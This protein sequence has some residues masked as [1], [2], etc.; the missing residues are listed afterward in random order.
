VELRSLQYFVTVAEELHFGRAAERLNIA[1][2]AVSQQVARLE[3]EL[4]VRLLDRSPRRV[5]LTPSGLRV[6]D[7]ARATLAAAA[8]VRVV[9]GE[10][11]ARVRIG[12]ASGLT[13][14]VERGAAFLRGAQRRTAP[15]LVDLPTPQRLDALRDGELDVALVR[16]PVTEPGVR[17]V[18]AWSEPLCA[19]VSDHNPISGRAT[20]TPSDLDPD[21]LRL[22][23]RDIDPPLYDAITSALPQPGR[24]VGSVLNVLIE[25]GADDRAWT[26][27]PAE[28]LAGLGS[29]RLRAI[30]F[31][32]PLTVDGHVVASLNTPD[33]CIGTFVSAFADHD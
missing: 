5:S 21:A 20:V 7:A 2:P 10:P 3:R 14:R 27:L 26:A 30:P 31:D 25:V 13:A 12:V 19:V 24:P 29:H 17:V 22:P 33:L 15:V 16:G 32:P 28:L 1:Q 8:R 4:G 18:R 11:A 9:A 6:L 23:S